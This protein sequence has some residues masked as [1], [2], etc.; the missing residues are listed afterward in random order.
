MSNET[1]EHSVGAWAALS[2]GIGALVTG[3]PLG[4]MLRSQVKTN[5]K[6][7]SELEALNKRMDSHE[8]RSDKRDEKIERIETSIHRR[9]DEMSKS[10]EDKHAQLLSGLSELRGYISAAVKHE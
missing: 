2:A 5:Q 7:S 10:Q 8:S 4:M 6:H 3:G 9:M 1:I